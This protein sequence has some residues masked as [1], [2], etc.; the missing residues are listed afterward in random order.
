MCL[1]GK[2]SVRHRQEHDRGRSNAMAVDCLPTCIDDKHDS[3]LM[4]QCVVALNRNIVTA[5]I[6][7]VAPAIRPAPSVLMVKRKNRPRCCYRPLPASYLPSARC[8]AY[9][10]FFVIRAMTRNGVSM[11]AAWRRR[12]N[13]T[14]AQ[15]RKG[16]R[17]SCFSSKGYHLAGRGGR[18]AAKA[19]GG[20]AY[21]QHQAKWHGGQHRSGRRK[22]RKDGHRMAAADIA[23]YRA[24]RTAPRAIA[25]NRAQ[26][27]NQSAAKM[28]AEWHQTIYK[29]KRQTMANIALF[30]CAVVSARIA[31]RSAKSNDGATTRGRIVGAFVA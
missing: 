8:L 2:L 16:K 3:L 25:R 28:A 4:A 31:S 19:Y 30:C 13:K 9:R 12:R 29:R 5:S 26:Q 23:S 22:R 18:R 14:A 20:M 27:R 11:A 7:S 17:C 1:G 10:K 15:Q 6:R 24:T 21:Q